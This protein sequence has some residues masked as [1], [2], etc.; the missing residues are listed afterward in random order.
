MPPTMT[1]VDPQPRRRALP[2]CALL[3]AIG[4]APAQRAAVAPAAR[5]TISVVSPRCA[6]VRSCLLGHVTV[7]N[8]A[9]PVAQA[10]VFLERELP[11]SDRPQLILRLTDEQG[12]F[13]V[14]DPPPGSYRIAVYKA[15]S[16]VEV[17]GM[18]LG[19]EGTIMLPVRLALE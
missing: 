2:T 17:M 8:S 14:H 13:A 4:C 12:V 11:G 1:T 19:G 7:A 16:R 6:G 18:Q 3:L 5:D 9:A 10:A 15:D